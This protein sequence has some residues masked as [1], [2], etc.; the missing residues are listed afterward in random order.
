ML[1][2]EKHKQQH[3]FREYPLC[4][5]QQHW[6]LMVK[7]SGVRLGFECKLWFFQGKDALEQTDNF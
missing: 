3:I 4:I 6:I 1:N 5:E 7:V 2:V